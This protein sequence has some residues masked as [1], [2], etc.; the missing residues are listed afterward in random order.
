MSTLKTNSIEPVTHSD[1]LVFRT[2]ATETMRL[3][4]DGSLLLGIQSSPDANTIIAGQKSANAPVL[5]RLYNPNT[6]TSALVALQLNNNVNNGYVVN[7][8]QNHA[9]FPKTVALEN[10][11]S[12]NGLLLWSGSAAGPIRFCAGSGAERMRLLSDGKFGIGTS[13]PAYKLDVVTTSN[14]QGQ[15]AFSGNYGGQTIMGHD[16]NGETWIYEVQNKGMRLGTNNIERIK[17]TNTGL[18]GIG[19]SSPSAQLT[20]D[21]A[22]GTQQG[23]FVNLNGTDAATVP[24][25]LAQMWTRAP[26][27]IKGAGTSTTRL[28]IGGD[29]N[30]SALQCSNANGG[31]ALPLSLQP[32]GGGLF[33]NSLPMFACRAWGSGTPSTTAALIVGQNCTATWAG[34]IYTVTLTTVMPDT[35]YVVMA[36]AN[37]NATAPTTVSITNASTFTIRVYGGSDN[38][39]NN[40]PVSWA[41]FR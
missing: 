16:L 19:T 11:N 29:E 30:G 13:T 18:V 14:E 3:A 21:G 17:I 38:L 5:S 37:Q 41:V 22:D 39:R 12:G 34:G 31:S 23:L 20:I 32:F 2:N 10:D 8:G 35:N 7:Y 25:T 40:S 4:T 28:L 26:V 33:H 36:T 24:T 9:S 1:P 15:I 6:G 27:H